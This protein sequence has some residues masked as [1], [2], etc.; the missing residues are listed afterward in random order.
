VEQG[1][2]AAESLKDHAHRLSEVVDVYRT[3]G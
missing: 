1:S 3:V 2:A